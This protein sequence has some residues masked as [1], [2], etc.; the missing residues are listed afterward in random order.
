MRTH[1]I[2]QALEK[3]EELDA[4]QKD[5]EQ[6]IKAIQNSSPFCQLPRPFHERLDQQIEIIHQKALIWNDIRS[7]IIAGG[8]TLWQ[9]AVE[10]KE[11]P[12]KR[13]GEEDM[14]DFGAKEVRRLLSQAQYESGS[15]LKYSEVM[16]CSS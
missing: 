3:M 8:K 13:F 9:L 15:L 2:E 6:H 7:F 4:K 5:L 16:L 12:V 14:I 1:E 10:N 11:T